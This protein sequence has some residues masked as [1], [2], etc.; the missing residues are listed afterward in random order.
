[1]GSY[2]PPVLPENI[3]KWRNNTKNTKPFFNERSN[4]NVKREMAAAAA[5]PSTVSQYRLFDPV[6][7]RKNIKYSAMP[8]KV[9]RQKYSKLGISIINRLNTL[10]KGLANKSIF[11]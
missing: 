2:V 4:N 5:A 6:G 7:N 11:F 1:M 8:N 9:N 10:E 3:S